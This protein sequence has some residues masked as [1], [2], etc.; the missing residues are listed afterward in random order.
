MHIK[1]VVIIYIN[2]SIIKIYIIN[3]I[4]SSETL[5]F[6][7]T[8]PRYFLLLYCKCTDKKNKILEQK[9]NVSVRPRPRFTRHSQDC[10]SVV[11]NN[12][13]LVG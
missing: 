7:S 6:L 11:F 8:F 1:I 10:R 3:I 4:C 5:M 2:V 9:N 12:K 13:S